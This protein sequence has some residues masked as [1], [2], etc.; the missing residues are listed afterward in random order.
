M[1]WRLWDYVHSGNVFD[2]LFA[3][4]F[5]RS[6][7]FSTTKLLTREVSTPNLLYRFKVHEIG[8]EA[9]LGNFIGLPI[10]LSHWLFQFN[11]YTRNTLR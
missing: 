8:A 2:V 11:Q 10:R 9:C 4:R 7:H 3:M 6:P 5:L 1:P